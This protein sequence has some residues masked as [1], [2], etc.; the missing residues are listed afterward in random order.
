MPKFVYRSHTVDK[1]EALIIEAFHGDPEPLCD[2]LI[3]CDKQQR[4]PCG[5]PPGRACG[6][7]NH[8]S[9]AQPAMRCCH[10]RGVRDDRQARMEGGDYRF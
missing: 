1:F 5:E 4:T 3:P 9:P 7:I 6:I 10:N 8:S 2:Y